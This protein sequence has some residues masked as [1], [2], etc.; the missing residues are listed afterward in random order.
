[1][2]LGIALLVF[3]IITLAKGEFLVSRTKS[4]RGTPAYVI[5][6]ILVGYLPLRFLPTSSMGS[7]LSSKAKANPRWTSSRCWTLGY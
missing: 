5:G 1:M 6:A 3:G 2:A 7:L 4:V